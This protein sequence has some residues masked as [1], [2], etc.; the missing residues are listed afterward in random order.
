MFRTAETGTAGHLPLQNEPN[1]MRHTVT[2]LRYGDIGD[3]YVEPGA[4]DNNR[5]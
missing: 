1:T 5:K 4:A 2:R 3:R